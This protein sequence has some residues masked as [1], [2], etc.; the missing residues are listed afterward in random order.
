MDHSS[1]KI[2]RRACAATPPTSV[3]RLIRS[4]VVLVLPWVLWLPR[5][6]CKGF[7]D[8]QVNSGVSDLV[9]TGCRLSRLTEITPHFWWEESKSR[10]LFENT[11]HTCTRSCS[12]LNK[13]KNKKKKTYLGLASPNLTLVFLI[14]HTYKEA[15]R[16]L[17]CAIIELKTDAPCTVQSPIS[18]PHKALVLVLM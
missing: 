16:K 8:L 5:R 4:H 14:D 13:M 3:C 18:H 7:V 1:G 12:S 2:H 11:T 10:A 6:M 15:N 9:Q 17:K